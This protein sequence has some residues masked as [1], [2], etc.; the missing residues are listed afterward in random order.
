[1][2]TSHSYVLLG[3]RT[4]ELSLLVEDLGPRGNFLLGGE[5]PGTCWHLKRGPMEYFLGEPVPRTSA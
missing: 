2:K 1:M 4:V 5:R 3:P